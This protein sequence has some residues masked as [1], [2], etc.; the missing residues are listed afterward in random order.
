MIFAKLLSS[1]REEIKRDL[2]DE[3]QILIKSLYS[4]GSNN[5]DIIDAINNLTKSKNNANS[6]GK[7]NGP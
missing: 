2:T 6:H 7:G 5:A 4:K 1:V 3:E